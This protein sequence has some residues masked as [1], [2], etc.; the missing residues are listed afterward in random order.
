MRT[1]RTAYAPFRKVGTAYIIPGTGVWIKR[2]ASAWYLLR[3]R[4]DDLGGWERL[5]T[6]STL[7]A[8]ANHWREGTGE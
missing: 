3:D 1:P 7:S 6:F 4:R 5:G 8:A 2:S